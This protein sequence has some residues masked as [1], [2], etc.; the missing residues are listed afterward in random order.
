M[1]ALPLF[2][3][4]RVFGLKALLIVATLIGA[5]AF[6]LSSAQA[7]KPN[8]EPFALIERHR[9]TE[10]IEPNGTVV[11]VTEM[12]TLIRSQLAVESESQADLPYN[13]TYASLE[14]LEAYTI[15]PQGQKIPVAANAIRTVD[16]DNSKGAAMFSDQKS[17]IIIF[18]KVTPGSRTYYKTRLTTHTPLMPGFFAA[19]ISFSPQTVLH[20]FQYT[21]TYPESMAMYTDFRG[22]IKATESLSNGKR[23]LSYQY[24]NL[25]WQK[26]ESHQISYSDFAPAI[27]ISTYP[28]YAAF[29]KDYEDRIKGKA[30]VTPEVQ[31]L[32]NTITKDIPNSKPREQA[33]ALYN[34]VA[35][36]IRYVA[37]YLGDG[38]IIPHD[39][40]SIIRNRYGDCKDHNTLLIALLTAKG[41]Q[42][43]TALI[44]Q[45]LSYSLPK[46]PVISPF[47]HV[48]TYLPQ[49]DLY[50]DS[51]AEMAPFGI[52]PS[53][54][55]DKPTLLTALQ[56]VGRTTK[57]KAELDQTSTK[58]VMQVNP[59]G[60]IKGKSQTRYVGDAEI[61]AR[62]KFEGADTT[63]AEKMVRSQLTKFRQTGEGTF[64]TSNVY[65]LDKPFT[66]ESEYVLDAMTNVPGP[67][68]MTI[69]VGVAP[70]E[71]AS[72]V[73]SR[74]P[75]SFKYPYRCSTRIVTEQYEI[76]F[77]DNVK[78][79]RIPQNSRYQTDEIQYESSYRLE[80]NKVMASRSLTIQRP[81]AVCMPEDLQAWRKFYSV[82]AKDVRGQ[83]FYE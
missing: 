10:T 22:P 49:W 32:A 70:G 54:Q 26:K 15:T 74:P 36:N 61:S 3:Y 82:L 81:N 23:T 67:G 68:A 65:D 13:S 33:R 78:V 39:A 17:K 80:G 46:Y 38:G 18:P 12:T 60:E 1:K 76:A 83:I 63:L 52:L 37:I 79:S 69:P 41:I 59:N 34:W 72:I 53:E 8:A 4:S 2:G 21:L 31:K 27:V 57:P 24:Q 51:T 5:Q 42:A 47:N 50:V 7:T 66:T 75:E 35:R 20:D 19:R 48:I 30:A 45:G 58:T 71:L 9:I 16:E 29:A 40:D 44:N 6:V 77:P 28:T 14:V 64:S 43:S 55:I 11:E 73:N 25:N 62:Y 56:K